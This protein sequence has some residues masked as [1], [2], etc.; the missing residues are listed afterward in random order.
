MSTVAE[1]LEEI[2]NRLLGGMDKQDFAERI[3]VTAG[4]YSNWLAGENRPRLNHLEVIVHRWHVSLDSL[5]ALPGTTRLEPSPTLCRI[6]EELLHK[7]SRQD[8]P[9]SRLDRIR[10]LH[11]HIQEATGMSE[12]S[13]CELLQIES[14][15]ATVWTDDAIERAAFLAGWYGEQDVWTV[16]LK[17][18][19]HEVFAPL[20][21]EHL[22]RMLERFVRK[23]GTE[24]DLFRKLQ[25]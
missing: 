23:G 25:G 1:R 22:V 24:V 3:G 8:M 7:L 12:E 5:L 16:W 6:Q 17:T 20:S 14:M 11:N 15:M 10:Y 19:Q 9:G 13:W 21:K 18:G 4:A 2:R